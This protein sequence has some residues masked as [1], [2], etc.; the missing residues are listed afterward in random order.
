MR[1]AP[2]SQAAFDWDEFFEESE[3]LP[4]PLGMA[5]NAAIS[6]ASSSPAAPLFPLDE[7]RQCCREVL[8]GSQA[9]VILQLGSPAGYGPLREYLLEVGRREG[10]VQS[11]D[12][13]LITNGVQQGL[14]LVQRLLVRAGD[15]VLLE[16]PIYPGIKHLLARAGARLIGVPVGPV[17]MD[18]ELAAEVLEREKPRLMVVTPNFHNP[19]GATLPV[20]ARQALLAAA[21]QAGT[22]VVE[23]DSY[24]ELRYS[25]EPAASLKQMDA[26]GGVILLRSF[27]KIAFPGLRVGWLTARRTLV[28]RLAE[29]KQLTDL[30]T[31]QLAQA[32]LLR[33]A[34]SGR[35]EAHRARVRA[36]GTERLAAVLEACARNLPAGSRHSRPQG[37]MNLWVKLPPPLDSAE[38]LGKAEQR[39]V[40]YL[41]GKIFEVTHHDPGGLRLSFA[42]LPPDKIRQGVAVL[43][44]LFAEELERLRAQKRPAPAPA[45]V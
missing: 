29:T 27:S 45:I 35:L 11:Q 17:G 38:L 14:D 22:V 37:G 9:Q 10:T 2:A 28:A 18:V 33:F 1:A 40:T 31:D 41:P 44:D 15:T 25:G 26:W 23:N 36:A 30:H 4:A 13:V 20:E 32:V 42:S 8:E 34:E 12:D 16:D 5:T 19:T 3:R 24:G 6:F 21:E 39:G 7:V 43:G